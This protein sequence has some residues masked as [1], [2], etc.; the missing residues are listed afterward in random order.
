[1]FHWY[2][3]NRIGIAGVLACL[4]FGG[5]EMF[6]MLN[7]H[8]LGTALNAPAGMLAQFLAAQFTEPP[9]LVRAGT[10]RAQLTSQ[11]V[12]G[13]NILATALFTLLLW[14]RTRMRRPTRLAQAVLALQTL[15]GVATMSSLLYVLAAQLA[16]VLPPRQGRRWLAAQIVLLAAVFL[17]IALFR[18]LALPDRMIEMLLIYGALGLLFQALTYGIARLAVRERASRATLARS[19]AALLAT[20]AMLADTVRATE[21]TRIARDLHD[22]VGHHLTALNLHL[23]LAMRQV[24]AGGPEALHTSRELARTLLTE[25][26]EVVNSERSDQHINLCAAIATMCAGIPAPTIRFDYDEQLEISS[27]VLAHTLFF[28]VQ[29]ALTNAIRHSGAELITIDIRGD[30]EQVLLE[31]HDDGCGTQDAPEGNGL[32][33][34]R[35]RVA[36]QCGTLRLG[37]A[38]GTGFGLAIALPL[39][40]S[41][42]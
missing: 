36:E 38:G 41:Y 30:D 10:A 3:K 22:A 8:E 7:D 1:M 2:R 18:H 12:I 26:R 20:Q 23:D 34:M 5:I 17:E 33:G 24:E 28:C 15:L 35:E 37:R 42:A 6:D 31:M 27:A 21:R 40:G 9:S 19:H 25:V 32:R 14:V 39:A 29:E 4:I 13:A 11:L 16:V